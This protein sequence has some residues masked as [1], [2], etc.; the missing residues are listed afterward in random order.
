MK[1]LKVLMPRVDHLRHLLPHLLAPPGDRHVEGIVGGRL[2]GLLVPG[3]QRLDQRLAGRRAARNRPIIVVPPESAARVPEEKS[4][5]RM[6][7]HE[8]HFEM[9]VRVDAARH[10]VA[11]GGVED[12][13]GAA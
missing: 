2:A 11:A 8:G 6:R 7:A 13:V 4:R 5:R 3:L 10:D 9:R 1:C 12:M